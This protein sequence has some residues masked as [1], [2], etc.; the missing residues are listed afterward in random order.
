MLF[1]KQVDASRHFLNLGHRRLVFQSPGERLWCE[2]G[3]S[4]NTHASQG[5]TSRLRAMRAATA[6]SACAKTLPPWKCQSNPNRPV[7]S[8][9]SATENANASQAQETLQFVFS[10][11]LRMLKGRILQSFQLSVLLNLKLKTITPF[12]QSHF[13]PY[14]Q[15]CAVYIFNISHVES[16]G[17]LLGNI[18]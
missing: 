5:G 9:H 1:P 4:S 6:S 12:W 13:S 14:F 18:S 17:F 8:P 16:N 15:A 11:S 3:R 10:G 2:R 7:Q